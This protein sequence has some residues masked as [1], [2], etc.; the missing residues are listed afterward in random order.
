MAIVANRALRPVIVVG[1]VAAAALLGRL[2]GCAAGGGSSSDDDDATT[3]TPTATLTGTGGPGGTGGQTSTG[4][5]AGGTGGQGATG[6]GA[7][8]TGASGGAGGA[9]AGGPCGFGSPMCILEWWDF[10]SGCPSGWS[11]Q[12]TNRDWACGPPNSGPF[13]DCEGSGNVW[14]TNLNGNANTCQNSYLISPE[15]DL[16]AYAGETV[17]FGFY[18]WYDFRECANTTPTWCNV[19]INWMSYSGGR[20]EVDSG[21]GWTPVTPEGGYEVGGKTIEC[22]GNEGGSPPCGGAG[23]DLDGTVSAYT[24]GGIEYQWHQGLVDIS[25][26]TTATF[27]ARFVFSSNDADPILFVNRA[28]WY[29]D[30]IAI[31][32]PGSC[33]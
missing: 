7:G 21:S 15:I 33:P 24:C 4:T 23:C 31:M 25:A 1:A 32:I 10:D 22:G 16:S 13:D 29:I 17:M 18:H 3:T 26:H 2:G 8:G 14:G 9:G 12:G 11:A 5:A 20:V 28:G 30:N 27:R 6:S 19:L